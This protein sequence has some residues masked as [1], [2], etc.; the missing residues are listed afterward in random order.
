MCR[1]AQ[2]TQIQVN[3]HRSKDLKVCLLSVHLYRPPNDLSNIFL[4]TWQKTVSA[5]LV[6]PFL[7]CE[8]LKLKIEKLERLEGYRG[9]KSLQD[10]FF[11]SLHIQFS[12]W[13][14]MRSEFFIFFSSVLISV[15]PSVS[16]MIWNT[17][18]CHPSFY[19]ANE[20]EERVVTCSCLTC[21][22]T[23]VTIRS[24]TDFFDIVSLNVGTLN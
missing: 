21:C 9:A 11:P 4:I 18:G 8:M 1:C 23:L 24:T 3:A 14:H 15:V 16:F 6:L 13:G 12:T 10:H 20:I 19:L 2:G 7:S 22:L 17:F 5:D